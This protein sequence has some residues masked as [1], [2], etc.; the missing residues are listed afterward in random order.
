MREYWPKRLLLDS[1]RPK[2]A[3]SA[4]AS[5]A[6]EEAAPPV[7][8]D[9]RAPGSNDN[10]DDDDDDDD[11]D[12]RRRARLAAADEGN[13]W[14]DELR[15]YLTDPMPDVDKDTDPLVYWSVSSWG[16]VTSLC[17][18]THCALQTYWRTYPTVGRMSLDTMAIPASS[19]EVK[20]LFSP[21]SKSPPTDTT[22]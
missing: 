9:A 14:E 18:L 15:R 5:G 12:R 13:G 1:G 19:V 3:G 4:R 10:D 22:G 2:D 21:A 7:S 11:F 16:F 20:E 6:D 8:G 17:L